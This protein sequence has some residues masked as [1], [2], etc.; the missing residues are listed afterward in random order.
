MGGWLNPCPKGTFNLQ[1][2]PSSL[3][4]LTPSCVESVAIPYELLVITVMIYVGTELRSRE[5]DF[6][7]TGY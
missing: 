4:A 5:F 3:V 7:L 2:A 1:D 6:I